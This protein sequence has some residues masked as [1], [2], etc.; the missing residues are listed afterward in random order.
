[1]GTCPESCSDSVGPPRRPGSYWG[2][3]TIPPGRTLTGKLVRPSRWIDYLELAPFVDYGRGWQT[4][5][6]TSDVLDLASVSIGPRWAATVTFPL[7]VRPLLEVSWGVPLR[8]LKTSGGNLQD[9]GLHLQ[10]ILAAF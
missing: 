1:V 8:N 9:K 6:P 10:F 3:P 5:Q 7:P 4:S 2:V